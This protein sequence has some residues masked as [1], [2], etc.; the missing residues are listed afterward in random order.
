[1]NVKKSD[2]KFEGYVYPMLMHNPS[3]VLGDSYF[4]ILALRENGLDIEGIILHHDNDC[5]SKYKTGYHSTIF[6]KTKFEPYDGEIILS[7]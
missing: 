7:N 5:G 4:V 6:N 2:K 1:M 3:P